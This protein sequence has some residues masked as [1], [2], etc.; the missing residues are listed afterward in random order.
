MANGLVSVPHI[1]EWP[2]VWE[3]TKRQIVPKD[4]IFVPGHVALGGMYRFPIL[5]SR[6]MKMSEDKLIRLIYN[7]DYEL[8]ESSGQTEEIRRGIYGKIKE[9]VGSRLSYS[10]EGAADA[11]E[12][13]WWQERAAKLLFNSVRVYE[14]WGYEWWAPL[15]DSELVDFWRRVPLG[16]RRLKS[17]HKSY[18]RELER[19]IAGLNIREY[20]PLWSMPPISFGVRILSKTPFLRYARRML[21]LR[22][23]DKHPLAWW[24]ILPKRAHRA[25]CTGKRDINSFL[26]LD[27]VRTLRLRSGSGQ[28]TISRSTPSRNG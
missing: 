17:L 22:E 8:Q 2:A 10:L 3:L 21:M 18:T 20:R 6:E 23:Y 4:S 1:Q 25:F 5:S 15:R 12:R 16:H 13:W 28:P 24:G 19:R 27:T 26:A 11:Y 7:T 9:V 14:Y